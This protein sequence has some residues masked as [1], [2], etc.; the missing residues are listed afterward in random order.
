MSLPSPQSIASSPGGRWSLGIQH[1]GRAALEV[2]R[3]DQVVAGA[4]AQRVGAAAAGEHVVALAAVELVAALAAEQ[5]VVAIAAAHLVLAAAAEEDVVAG[6][7]IGLAV[8]EEQVVAAAAA[9]QIGAVAAVQAA[10]VAARAVVACR[11]GCGRCRG[12]RARAIVAEASQHVVAVAAQR[13]SSPWPAARKSSP[14]PP[15]SGRRRARR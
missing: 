1:V 13:M 3:P 10:V 5:Q 9:D 14:S 12:R 15:S 7:A 4:G 11:R 2:R 8:A 6:S